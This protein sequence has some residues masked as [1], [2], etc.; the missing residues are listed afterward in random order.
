MNTRFATNAHFFYESIVQVLMKQ[1]NTEYPNEYQYK[2]DTKLNLNAYDMNISG[3][4]YQQHG[5]CL[6]VAFFFIHFV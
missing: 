3:S 1:I 2:L 5:Y 6:L 4:I